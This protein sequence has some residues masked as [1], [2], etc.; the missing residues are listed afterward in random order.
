M[1]FKIDEVHRWW[2]S[3]K[4]RIIVALIVILTFSGLIYG[5]I[6]IIKEKLSS[7]LL[8]ADVIGIIIFVPLAIFAMDMA[9][10]EHP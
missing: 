10:Y 5:L 9:F 7:I 1:A 4:L 3:W 6:L 2:Q 8:I